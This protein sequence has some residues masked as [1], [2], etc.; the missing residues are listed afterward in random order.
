LMEMAR[1]RP[2]SLDEMADINGVGPR[3]LE[4]FGRLFLDAIA[5]QN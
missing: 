1:E 5:A 2:A 3:K 4:G